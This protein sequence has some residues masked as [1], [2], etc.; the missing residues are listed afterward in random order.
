MT[1]CAEKHNTLWTS[2]DYAQR[3]Y[4]ITHP[5]MDLA[6]LLVV[7]F[8]LAYVYEHYAALFHQERLVNLAKAKSAPMKI[9][10][11]VFNIAAILSLIHFF[12]YVRKEALYDKVEHLEVCLSDV[13]MASAY[14]NYDIYVYFGIFLVFPWFL[15]LIAVLKI[16]VEVRRRARE[17]REIRR[18]SWKETFISIDVKEARSHV[19]VLSIGIMFLICYGIGF[20]LYIYIVSKSGVVRTGVLCFLVPL[21]W[22]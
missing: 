14:I 10:V 5:L 20:I 7:W 9:I 1:D 12:K 2:I 21:D 11:I 4:V 13:Y 16:T 15:V 8:T 17:K 3:T 22:R 19:V 6:R 18:L